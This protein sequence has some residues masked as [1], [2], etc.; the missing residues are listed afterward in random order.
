ME[1]VVD[2]DVTNGARGEIM[3]IILHPNEP[4]IGDAPIVK[5]KMLPSFLLVK[6]NRTRASKLEGLEEGVIPVEPARN[7]MRISVRNPAG[8][9]VQRT[10]NRR[11]FPIT[12]AYAFTD[13]R[14]QGQTLP[15][16]LVDIASPPF[17]KPQSVQPIRC[18]V[19]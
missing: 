4:S 13:Y 5:L 18:L 9:W 11:Q 1:R 15:Y 3:A 10:V 16:V 2:L 6:L 19:A 12:A 7:S 17:R 14:S 8:K